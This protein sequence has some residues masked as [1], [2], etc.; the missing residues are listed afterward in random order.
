MGTHTLKSRGTG[1]VEASSITGTGAASLAGLGLTGIWNQ[2]LAA[3]GAT[4][5]RLT[6]TA[7]PDGGGSQG[8][9]VTRE[10]AEEGSSVG[11]GPHPPDASWQTP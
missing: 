4:P 5:T 1:T 2:A 10:T 3:A 11:E 6:H 8:W 9:Q 7:E